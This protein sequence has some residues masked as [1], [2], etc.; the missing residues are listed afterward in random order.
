MLDNWKTGRTTSAQT[1]EGLP[2]RRIVRISLRSMRVERRRLR[3]IQLRFALEPLHQVRIRD[4]QLAKRHGIRVATR[5]PLIRCR[6]R[7]L[8][9]RNIDPAELILQPRPQPPRSLILARHQE[10]D[11][12]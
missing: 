5:Y 6:I 11:L 10:R 9:I 1:P 12:S 2:E 7:K 3:L 4:P 8:F